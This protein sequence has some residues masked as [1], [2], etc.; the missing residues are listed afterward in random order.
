LE[1]GNWDSGTCGS[2]TAKLNRHKEV[3]GL[4]SGK[5]SPQFGV[6][7]LQFKVPVPFS[8]EIVYFSEV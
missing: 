5:N 4:L 2:D 3:R 8:A 6:S 7:I 1:E